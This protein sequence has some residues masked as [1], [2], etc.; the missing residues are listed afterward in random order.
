TRQ[1]YYQSIWGSLSSVSQDFES[2][3]AT[4]IDLEPVEKKLPISHTATT[5]YDP[6]IHRLDERAQYLLDYYTDIVRREY[7]PVYVE[8][9]EN[10]MFNAIKIFYPNLSVDEIRVRTIIELACNEEHYT[11]MLYSMK[12][13]LVDDETVQEHVLRI[14][15]NHEYTGVHTLAAISSI[16]GRRI[17]SIYPNINDNDGYFEL[18]NRINEPRQTDSILSDE[19]LRVLWSGPKPDGERIWRPNHFVPVLRTRSSFSSISMES[20][21]DRDHENTG[22]PSFPL[23][24]ND[25]DVC[26]NDRHQEISAIN[27][28]F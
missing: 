19:P 20:I 5:V 16:F 28:N 2:F 24:E 8:V 23:H 25:V 4:C 13:D 12:L 11:T 9:D 14:M 27:D 18:L 10:C 21:T 17:E 22:L 7:S 26:T 6:A 1:N 3:K 15:N